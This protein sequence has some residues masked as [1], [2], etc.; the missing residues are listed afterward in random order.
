MHQSTLRAAK[1][2]T[3]PKSAS[4]FLIVIVAKCFTEHMHELGV[5]ESY[6]ISVSVFTTK[7]TY[8]TYHILEHEKSPWLL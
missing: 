6:N 2:H 3:A 1:G 7:E 4:A 8:S 5:T